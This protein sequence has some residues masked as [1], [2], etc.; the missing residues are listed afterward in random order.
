MHLKFKSKQLLLPSLNN[1]G[2]AS[3]PTDPLVR[4]LNNRG[5]A[6]QPTD[7]YDMHVR[8]PSSFALRSLS[9]LLEFKFLLN[10]TI[11]YSKSLMK[12]YLLN[13]Q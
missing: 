3:Q 7:P 8:F 10:S 2:L 6:S 9:L 4:P 5:L 1:R 13:N 11:A 12:K